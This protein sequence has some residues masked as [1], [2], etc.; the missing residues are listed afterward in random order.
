MI[1]LLIA[2]PLLGSLAAWLTRDNRRR[3]VILPVV[4]GLHLLLTLALLADTPPP[5]MGGWIVLDPLGKL[6]LLGISILFIACAFYSVGYLSYRRERSNRVLC[7][8]LSLCL[9]AMSLAC[10]CQH[11]GLLWVAI[12]S[13]TLAMAPL[14]YFNRN[15]RSIEATWNTC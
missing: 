15:A 11:L 1:A 10:V 5:A 7:M 4:A 14:I 3:P 12:E 8:G 13:T 6:V 9:S 2:I